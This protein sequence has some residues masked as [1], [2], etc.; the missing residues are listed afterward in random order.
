MAL[1]LLGSLTTA[2]GRNMEPRIDQLFN[3]DWK[4]SMGNP[5]GAE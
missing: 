3:F 1:M 5:E 4:F 2:F